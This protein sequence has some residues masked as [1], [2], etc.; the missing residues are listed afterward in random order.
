MRR[1]RR[2]ALVG[3]GLYLGAF[4][5]L[6]CMEDLLLYWPR[7]YASSWVT[8]ADASE[9]QDVWLTLEDGSRVHGWWMEPPNWSADKGVLLHCHP[10]GANISYL[11][12]PAR[13]FRDKLDRAVLLFDYPGFGKSEGAASEA[14]CCRS[15]EAAWQWLLHEKKLAPNRIAIHG[16]SLGGAVAIELA[17][18]HPEAQA[19]IASA[20]FTTF[21]EVAQDNVLVFPCSFC[22]NRF[23]SVERIAVV[24]TPVLIAHGTQDRRIPFGHG[25]RL[26]AAATCIRKEFVRVEEGTHNLIAHPHVLDAM[27]TFLSRGDSRL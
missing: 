25:E 24:K 22:R 19:L 18:R 17:S 7:T 27:A 14:G 5:A 13:K 8:P 16:H 21:A 23:P 11:V 12:G 15:A 6:L 1:L 20:T 3:L 9:L 26:F 10:K 4:V 2:L